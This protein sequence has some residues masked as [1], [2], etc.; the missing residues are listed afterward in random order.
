MGLFQRIKS[1]ITYLRGALRVLGSISGIAKNPNRT[2]CD[3]MEE[4]A[5]KYG[6]APA[7]QSK[8]ESMS[9]RAYNERSNQYMRWA[10][11]RGLKK[12]DC[13]ALLMP[14]RVEYLPVWLGVAKAGGVTALLNTNLV[15]H[16]LAHCINIVSPKAVIVD[17][18]LRENFETARSFLEGEPEIWFYDGE[19]GDNQ[20]NSAVD[21]MSSVN[22]SAEEKTPLTINDY[23]L[24]IYTSGTTG[25]PKAANI[26]H[27]RIQSIIYGFSSAGEFKPSDK[28]YICLPL[29]HTTGGV[30][31]PGSVFA[32]GG[33]AY[34][35]PRFSASQFWDD[36]VREECT[37]FQYIGEM[38]RYLVNSEPSALETKHKLRIVSG[39]GL[40]PDVWDDFKTRFDIPQILEWYAA[41]ESNAVFLNFDGKPGAVGRIPKWAEKRFVT[42][43][44]KYD[45][46]AGE[47]I[48]DDNGHLIECAPNEPGEV[49]S[50]IMND[51]KRPSQRFE[52][53]SDKAATSKKIIENAFETGDR[54]FRSGDL[55][56]KDELGY[57]YFVD[58]IG[59]TFRW[60]AENVSTAEVAETLTSY[61]G[62]EE[63]N[64]YG[65][66]IT[67]YDGR[68]G[69]AALVTGPE[70]KLDGFVTFL[71]H[72]LP[73][74]AR[75]IFIRLQNELEA[76]GT[77][78]VKKINL[79]R[80]G[81]DPSRI[82]DPMLFLKPDSN[83]YEPLD[84]TAFKQIMNQEIR[85]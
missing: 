57:F 20:L 9:Y 8:D 58:R 19:E 53:Y 24:F 47:L 63:A 36:I 83:L 18:S 25:M 39:N 54:W 30:M 72:H 42:K 41:T 78:K 75:P 37:A 5:V 68:A 15:D 13:I 70:F 27:Y 17:G 61:P 12:G 16:S 79:V 59:D 1:E 38:C 73:S 49:I 46:E 82:K 85:L 51:P 76:T 33:T 22:P 21:A 55:L 10:K 29:Y 40:R 64:V 11:E 34:I 14:N 48:R 3:F 65:V 81:F 60:K 2:I 28:I 23:C 7:I 71:E 56:R 44:V 84:E 77:F 62:I 69:M 4:I 31:A 66:Q 45:I 52:G 43:V 67:G 80:E 6:D 35:A 32:A 74:Y 50:Q 26:N